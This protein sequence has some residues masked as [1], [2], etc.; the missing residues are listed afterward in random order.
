MW[1]DIIGS[2]DLTNLYYRAVDLIETNAQEQWV[3][4]LLQ[5]WKE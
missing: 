5:F 1:T 3:K 4:D 2:M